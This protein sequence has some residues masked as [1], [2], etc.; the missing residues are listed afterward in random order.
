MGNKVEKRTIELIQQADWDDIVPR[1]MK[2]ALTKLSIRSG[3][4]LEGYSINEIA[5]DIVYNSIK[6][7]IEGKRKWEP[8]RGPLLKFVMFS[9]IR[10][11]I[12]H[13]YKSDYYSATQRMPVPQED[14]DMNPV[15]RD[16]L[17]DNVDSDSNVAPDQNILE[18]EM[19]DS[20]FKAVEGDN[21]LSDIVL[22]MYDGI[23]KPED[24]A[25]Q[26]NVDVKV[27]YN[28]KKRLRRIYRDILPTKK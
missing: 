26:L 11:E 12:S 19:R 25:N 1:L 8:D 3:S 27:I 2:Y 13:L 24:I 14:G 6:K 4:P 22:C 7:V 10:S 28:A 9:V 23:D 21:E 17:P 16:D 15:S 18:I 20:I 5:H